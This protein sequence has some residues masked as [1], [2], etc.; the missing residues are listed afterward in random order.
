MLT[1]LIAQ[2]CKFDSV[3][4][5]LHEDMMLQEVHDAIKALKGQVRIRD[6]GR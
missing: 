6:H 3:S 1:L 5:T 4:T 2:P